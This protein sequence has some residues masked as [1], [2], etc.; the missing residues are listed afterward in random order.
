MC[1]F[2]SACANSSM[3]YLEDE[4]DRQKEENRIQHEQILALQG[5]LHDTESKLHK[6]LAENEE[7]NG[8]L[9]ITKDN[10]GSLAVELSEFKARYYEVE[11]L[12]RDAQEQLRKLRK[13]QVPGARISLFSSLGQ[14]A[15]GP[16]DSLQSELEMSIHS[17]LSTDSGICNP[18]HVPQ[19]KKVFETVR[20]ASQNSLCSG[21]SLGSLHSAMGGY[22]SSTSMPGGGPRM[23]VRPHVATELRRS[24]GSIYSSSSLGYPS[25]DSTGYSDTEFSQ[26]DSDDGYP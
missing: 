23:S 12:L 10:Q 6:I 16:Y 26:T 18:E 19:Y 17:E 8:L 3:G 25:I 14:T 15:V 24:S 22:V 20:C 21:D 13:K 5:Q 11:A 1:K 7:I 9:Q 2:F 4:I